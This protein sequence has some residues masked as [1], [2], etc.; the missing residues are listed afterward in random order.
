MTPLTRTAI[1]IN[2]VWMVAAFV[3]NM[4][5][6][7]PGGP[8]SRRVVCLFRAFFALV[9]GAAYWAGALGILDPRSR[10]AELVGNFLLAASVAFWPLCMVLPPLVRTPATVLPVPDTAD[11]LAAAIRERLERGDE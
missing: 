10:N 7:R 6:A 1:S 3:A 4:W 5:G 2:A 11:R 8:F 9:F